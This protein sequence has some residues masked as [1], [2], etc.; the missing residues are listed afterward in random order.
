[1]IYLQF[2]FSGLGNDLIGGGW[3]RVVTGEVELEEED[4]DK[5]QNIFLSGKEY[6]NM[7]IGFFKCEKGILVFSSS[8]V[9]K[10][11]HFYCSVA[12]MR[13]FI[14]YRPN[15]YFQNSLVVKLIFNP[16][17]IYCWFLYFGGLLN[18]G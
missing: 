5:Y 14:V 17:I 3:G 1:M 4:E 7:V 15:R 10:M 16:S 11:S 13:P 6:E 9:T 18:K 12:K 8:P 2:P